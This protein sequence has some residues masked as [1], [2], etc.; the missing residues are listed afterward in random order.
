[1]TGIDAV[2]PCPPKVVCAWSGI[3]HWE[4]SWKLED[5]RASLVLAKPKSGPP[6]N[7]PAQ[8]EWDGAPVEVQGGARCL[9]TRAPQPQP[10]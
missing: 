2:S 8:L 9:Y 10:P 1:V 7:L 6:L 5:G 3:V 4:G